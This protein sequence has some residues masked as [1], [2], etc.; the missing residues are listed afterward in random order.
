[1]KTP[2]GFPDDEPSRAQ[3]HRDRMARKSRDQSSAVADIGDIPLV[4]DLA[5][6][7]R[8]RLDLFAFLTTYFPQSTGLRPLSADHARFITRLQNCILEGGLF[9]EAMPRGFAKTTIGENAV[10]WATLYGHRRFVPVFGA[11]NENAKGNIDSIKMELAENDLL[12]E[13]FPEVCHP[14]RALEN[15]VQRCRSQTHNSK[16]THIEWTADTIVLPSIEG[17]AASGAIITAHGLLGASRGMKYKRPD[18]TQQRPDFAFIDDPQTDESAASPIQVRKRLGIIKKAVLKS[19]GHGKKLACFA[20]VTVIAKDDLADQLLNPKLNPAWQSERI[21]MVKAWSSAHETLWQE[22]A[23]KRNTYN[24]DDTNDQRRAH[25]QATDFYRANL[26]AMDDGCD[27]SWEHCYDPEVEISAIQH[28]Y[29]AL[30]DDGPEVFASEYQN[31]PLEETVGDDAQM[32]AVDIAAKMNGLPRGIV[33]IGCEHVTAHID[34]QESSLWWTVVAWSTRFDG[35]VLDYGIWPEQ[36]NRRYITLRDIKRT[37][38]DA[39]AATAKEKGEKVPGLEGAIYHGLDTLTTSILTREWRREDGSVLKVAQ[40]LVD[41]NWQRSADA[42]YLLAKQSKL[43][44][45]IMPAHGRGIGAMQTPMAEHR[46]KIG[47]RVGLNWRVPTLDGRRSVRHVSYDTNYWKSFVASRLSTPTGDTG[48]MSLFGKEA[49]THKG[50]ADHYTSEYPTTV[51]AKGRKVA[52]WRLRP[53]RDN[54]WLDNIVGCAVAASMLGCSLMAG[55]EYVSK[56]KTR[57]LR[58]SW[59]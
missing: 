30:I 29:N 40:L 22:Y 4:V 44:E 33:P 10:M 47:D 39:A 28:A 36:G 9:I 46:K 35:Y 58:K 2:T 43:S 6:R 27:I 3:K 53:G 26:A 49:D 19:A 15:K 14:V 24:P 50:I 12:M 25:R 59:K 52:E 38:L 48:C 21:K 17:S 5:R 23:E 56:R 31:E 8:C 45:K 34:V 32:K 41:A 42:I 16:L 1:M 13:D 57:P 18:G 54:H 7:E 37:M 55:G 11:A 51:E 20:A